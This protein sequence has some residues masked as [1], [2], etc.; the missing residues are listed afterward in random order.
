M[1]RDQHESGTRKGL[2]MVQEVKREKQGKD[3]KD[4]KEGE[5]G[6]QVGLISVQ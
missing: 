5:V 1:A 3:V 2:N 6:K 4:R